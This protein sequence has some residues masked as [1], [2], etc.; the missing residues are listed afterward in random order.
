ML[1]FATV[2]LPSAAQEAGL[3]Q[4]A[5]ASCEK[6]ERIKPN[7]ELDHNVMLEGQVHDQNGAPFRNSVVEL[8]RYENETTQKVVIQTKTDADGYFNLGYI[9]GGRYRLLASPTRAFKQAE[10][11]ECGIGRECSLPIVLEA[12]QT[13]S[14]IA[15]CPVR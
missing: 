14:P 3:K 4:P 1:V 2:V 15:Q 8:R 6:A 5:P 10:K 12:E 13:D 11:L 7:F 9:H